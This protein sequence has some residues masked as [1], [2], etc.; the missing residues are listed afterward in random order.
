MDLKVKLQ[1]GTVRWIKDL[2][3]GDYVYCSDG[4]TYPVKSIITFSCEAFTIILSNFKKYTI[5]STCKM[6][7]DRGMVFPEQGYKVLG[8]KNITPFVYNVQKELLNHLFYDILIDV[9]MVS[10]EGFVFKTGV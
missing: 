10:T 3:V 7:T 2:K 6:Q 8:V 5:P 1:N 4:K 9:P